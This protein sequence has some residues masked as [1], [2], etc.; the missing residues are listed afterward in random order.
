MQ[1][2]VSELAPYI[3]YQ[4]QKEKMSNYWGEA[5]ILIISVSINPS[6]RPSCC[7]NE[8]GGANIRQS[9]SAEAFHPRGKHFN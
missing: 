2:T 6:T 1:Q 5:F 3:K 9:S 7:I 8:G 4:P